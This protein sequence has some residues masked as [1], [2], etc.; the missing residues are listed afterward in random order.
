MI[1]VGL[2]SLGCAKNRID[3]EMMLAMF[4]PAFYQLTDDPKEANLIIVNT[5][6]FIA[7]AKKES[8]DTI[9]EMCQYGAKVAV[10]GCLAE[11]YYDELKASLTE[12]SLIVPIRK[13]QDLPE[14]LSSLT[15][16][17]GIAPL[18]P[19]KRIVST[20]KY[21]AYLRISEGCNNFC[22][23]CAIPYIR[24]RFVSRPYEEILAEAKELH[25]KGVKEISLI[26]QDTTRYGFDFKGQRPNIVDLLK[27][28][29]AIGFYSIRLLYL[30]PDEISDELIDL[31]GQ[32]KSIAHYFDIPVQA[33]S[34]HLLKA[35][36]R[37]GDKAQMMQLFKTI[38]A[39]VPDAILRT[40][41]IA[42][43]PG[44]SAKDQA[45]TLQFLKDV[46][47]DHMGCFT[48]SR[49]EGTA[50]YSFSHQIPEKTKQARYGELMK[51]QKQISYEKNKARIGQVMEGLVVGY[52]APHD[53][54]SLRSTWNAPDDIDGTISFASGRPLALG[55]VVRVKITGAFV[56]DLFGER[57]A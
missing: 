7:A 19:L 6:G 51:L 9:L 46:R 4:D 15:G 22:A 43:F 34:D 27:A 10:V 2:V 21:S 17:G 23:F 1:K 16:Q 52:D 39:K 41:L 5:C 50:A 56:Y 11:R 47:F 20:P 28:I 53:L 26:S 55:E 13:Y 42:G 12:A 40:T 14:L 29:E 31:I 30:Y 32:S 44:E 3:S 48:Y 54:Y 36:R 38:K 33:G 37:H 57:I 24:G 49:E 18:N 45:E 8:I 25:A 35:M